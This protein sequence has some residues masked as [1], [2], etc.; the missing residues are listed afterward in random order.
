MESRFDRLRAERLSRFVRSHFASAKAKLQR[1]GHH[2]AEVEIEIARYIQSAPHSVKFMG[3]PEVTSS[4][5]SFRVWVEVEFKRP[6]HDLVPLAV[7]DVVQNLR[8]ALDHL[9]W[10][11]VSISGGIPDREL[12]FPLA[13][14]EPGFLKKLKKFAAWPE[15][16]EILK[17]TAAYEG[18]AG[19]ILS[20][21]QTLSNIDKHRML[22]PLASASHVEGVVFIEMTTKERSPQGII[23]TVPVTGHTVRAIEAPLGWGFDARLPVEAFPAIYFAEEGLRQEPLVVMLQRIHEAVAGVLV[24]AE[25]WVR[26][27][28]APHRLRPR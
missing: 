9:A 14:D 2:I 27:Q 25:D 3:S 5:R 13:A 15:M 26:E 20:R 18:G 11:I 7:G 24:S 10:E 16:Y 22:T 23:S 12:Y 21:L 6:V 19:D 28:K 1:G 4:G 8:S 17:A